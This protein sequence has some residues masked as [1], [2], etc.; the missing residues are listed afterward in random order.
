AN[1]VARHGPGVWLSQ[2]W[3]SRALQ[4]LT[5]MKP[6][7][8][9]ANSPAVTG[10]PSG[11]PT[12][13]TKPTPPPKPSRRGGATPEP[14]PTPETERWRRA[15]ARHSPAGVRPELPGRPGHRGTGDHDRA[16]PSVV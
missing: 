11:E 5:S 13:T 6:N 12:P 14:A 1:D 3:M 15:E 10:W 9:S 16:G 4:S 2:T 8:C 7:A